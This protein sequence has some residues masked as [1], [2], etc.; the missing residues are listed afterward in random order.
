MRLQDRILM[1]TQV[2]CRR[3]VLTLVALALTL[4]SLPAW[5]QDGFTNARTMGMAGAASGAGANGALYVN[6]AGLMALSMYSAEAGY[7]RNNPDQRNAFGISLV[8]SQTN[9]NIAAGVG[10]NYTFG[11]GP[12]ESRDDDARDHDLRF[13]LAVPVVPNAVFL[14]VG[15]HYTSVR[16]IKTVTTQPAVGLPGTE[17]VTETAGRNNVFTVDA[18]LMATF[19]RIIAIGF[20]VQNIAQPDDIQQ[21]RRYIGGLGVYFGPAHFEF[22]YST[23]QQRESSEYIGTFAG[24]AEVTIARMIPL[25]FGVASRGITPGA[26]ISAGAGYR[27]TSAGVDLAYQ[28]STQAGADRALMAS[29]LFYR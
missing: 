22:Q 28:Q 18:G 10:Y 1:H 11:P 4:C 21:G 29:F 16:G 6:P 13:A 23:E 19:Q 3:V 9:P 14:G 5:A 26:W 8:D 25:R 17:T 2:S 7:H 24:A 27:S 15:G 20:S 12:G